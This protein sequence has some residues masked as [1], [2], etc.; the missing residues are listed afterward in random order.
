MLG[1][2]KSEGDES[3]KRLD[4]KIAVATRSKVANKN[5]EHKIAS[6][7]GLCCRGHGKE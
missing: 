5:I 2:S 4:L 6:L 7:F 3:F 1:S